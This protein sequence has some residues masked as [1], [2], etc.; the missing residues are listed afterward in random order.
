[1]LLDLF[2]TVLVSVQEF[3]GAITHRNILK[4]FVL[5]FKQYVFIKTTFSD[6]V[7]S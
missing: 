4:H 1:M 6:I 7:P 2:F 5:L 3:F